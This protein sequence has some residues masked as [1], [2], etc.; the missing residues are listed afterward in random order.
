MTLTVS[1]IFRVGPT[2]SGRFDIALTL[3]RIFDT[4]PTRA[5]DAT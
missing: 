3:S 4:R 1:R 2:L 5:T